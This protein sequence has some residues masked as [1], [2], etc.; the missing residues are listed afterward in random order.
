MTGML[1]VT[2]DEKT[3][4]ILISNYE[5]YKEFDDPE[6]ELCLLFNKMGISSFNERDIRRRV[7]TLKLEKGKEKAMEQFNNL[8]KDDMQV[9]QRCTFEIMLGIKIFKWLILSTKKY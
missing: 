4:L 7:K 8:Y 1:G 9:T 5:D 2:W 3:D 6:T